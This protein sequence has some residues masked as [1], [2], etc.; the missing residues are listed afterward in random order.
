MVVSPWQSHQ[1]PDS[2]REFVGLVSYLPLKGWRG[3]IRFQRYVRRIRR[4]LETAEGLV[5]YS[6]L[7]RFLE[8][9]FWT[10]SAWDDETSLMVFV[11]SEPHRTAMKELQPVMGPT[12][13]VR[14]RVRGSE[15]PL[16]WDEGLR[17]VEST[18]T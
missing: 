10:F 1:R 7:A 14:W 9:R 5:G 11:L 4:Q 3:F 15:V 18:S 8:R 2:N 13:F 16:S 12:K 6:L 17:R